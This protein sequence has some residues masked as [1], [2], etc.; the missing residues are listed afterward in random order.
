M[1]NNLAGLWLGIKFY[2][3]LQI[4]F[5]NVLGSLGFNIRHRLQMIKDNHQNAWS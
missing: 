5:N 4:S 1:T 3:K 2:K